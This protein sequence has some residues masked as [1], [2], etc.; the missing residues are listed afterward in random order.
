MTWIRFG[1]K[2]SPSDRFAN[3]HLG[4]F[5]QQACKLAIVLGI[6]MLHE[7]EGH[8]CVRRQPFEQLHERLQSARRGP[9]PGDRK[10]RLRFAPTLLASRLHSHDLSFWHARKVFRGVAGCVNRRGPW[11]EFREAPE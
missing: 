5:F 11:R 10:I 2:I 8:A 4:G 9:D 7:H 1:R 3:R 6:Q